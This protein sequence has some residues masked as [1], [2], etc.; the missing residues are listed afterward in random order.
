PAASASAAVRKVIAAVRRRA[1]RAIRLREVVIVTCS[2]RATGAVMRRRGGAGNGHASCH[3]REVDG[4][5][6]TREESRAR[7]FWRAALVAR[8]VSPRSGRANRSSEGSPARPRT[9]RESAREWLFPP[10][11]AD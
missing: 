5:A 6:E 2:L 10:G 8:A 1:A 3:L 11:D 7:I 9:P 4:P